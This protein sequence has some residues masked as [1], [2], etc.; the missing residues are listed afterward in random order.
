VLVGGGFKE[1]IVEKTIDEGLSLCKREAAKV[2]KRGNF[3]RKG[4]EAMARTTTGSYLGKRRYR[5][6]SR[7]NRNWGGRNQNRGEYGTDKCI[8]K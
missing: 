2:Q 6:G 7:V 5:H 8:I 4:G 1:R 3:W